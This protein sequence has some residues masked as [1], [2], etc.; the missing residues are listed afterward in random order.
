MFALNRC[1]LNDSAQVF[2]SDCLAQYGGF[3]NEPLA[4]AVVGVALE[5]DFLLPHAADTP[6]RIAAPAFLEALASQVVASAD[7]V[8][9]RPSEALALAVG[10]QLHNA[11]IDTQRPIIWPAFWWGD[12]KSTRLNSSHTVISYAVFFLKKK[13]MPCS[14][15][16]VR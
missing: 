8:N 12:R 16:G 11:Q 5:A 9:N 3:L 15:L 6:L 13:N 2:K 7:E 1:S 14:I 4:D 10:G